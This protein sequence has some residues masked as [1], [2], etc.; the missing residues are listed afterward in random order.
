MTVI[1][2]VIKVLAPVALLAGSPL[3]AS[4]PPDPIKIEHV[5]FKGTGCPDPSTAAVNVS[6]DKQALTVTFS[7]FIAEAGPSIP[8]SGNRKNCTLTL[9]LNIPSGWQFSIG[10][11][12]FRG[13]VSLDKGVAAEHSATYFLQGDSNQQKFL[14]TKKGPFT[15][16]YVYTDTIGIESKVWTSCKLGIK[17][18]LSIN[19]AIRAWN[20]NK[21]KYPN[22]TGLIT[23]DS[24]DGEITQVWG[25]QWRQ[26]SPS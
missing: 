25:V 7:E 15:D 9:D 6:P 16:D 23:N 18:A 12:N 11:F 17:R 13:F 10:T 26:C 14:S 22:A 3:F 1:Q 4:A 21:D 2:S 5:T 24:V 19:T 20:T 8:A